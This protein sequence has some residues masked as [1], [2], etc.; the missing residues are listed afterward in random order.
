MLFN[1]RASSLE[2]LGPR[3]RKWRSDYPDSATLR[4]FLR[5]NMIASRLPPHVL[6]STIQT[7]LNGW[8]RVGSVSDGDGCVQIGM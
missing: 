1:Q 2:H 7:L 4:T 8:I 5:L 3:V 6:A